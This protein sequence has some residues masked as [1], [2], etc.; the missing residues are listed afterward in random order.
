MDE[1]GTRGDGPGERRL[2]RPPSARY[3]PDAA[4]T[5]AETAGAVPHGRPLWYAV[6]VAIAGALA[7]AVGGGL[8]AMTAGLLA[9]AGLVGWGIAV[10]Y[11]GAARTTPAR[12]KQE[13]RVIAASLGV[14]A[15]A[16]GQLG[17]WLIAR[18]EGGTLGLIDYLGQ[19]FGILVPLQFAIAA[20]IAWW[21][22]G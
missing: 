8:L 4:T 9:V 20:L 6:L 22:T 11:G 21:R 18:Q 5:T 16:A 15:V 3:V 1:G 2:E 14:V 17:L 12:R 13:R 7:I 10:V 19:V